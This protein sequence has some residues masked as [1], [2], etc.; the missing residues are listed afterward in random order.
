MGLKYY[1]RGSLSGQTKK[2]GNKMT[3]CREGHHHRSKLEASVCA[4]LHLRLK[5]GEIGQIKIEDHLYLTNAKIGYVVDFRCTRPDGRIFWVEAKGHPNDTWPI[6][7][8][9]W[10]IYGPG[11]LEIWKGTYLKPVLEEIIEP[12]EVNPDY[13]NR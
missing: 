12:Q 9:L 3:Q 13:L 10:K 1:T 4:L 6:K 2:M 8:K 7:K 5:A 11:L